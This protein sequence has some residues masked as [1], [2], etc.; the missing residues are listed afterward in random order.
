MRLLVGPP[1]SG[2][3][4]KVLAEFAA[5]AQA[6]PA[7]L[8]VPTATM[9]EHL[10]HEL[11]RQG[12]HVRPSWITTLAG[13]LAEL[14]PGVRIAGAPELAL[15]VELALES[16]PELFCALRGSPGL[17]GALASAIDE[18]SAAGVDAL[19]LESLAGM[20]VAHPDRDLVGLYAAAEKA[21][22]ASGLRLRAQALSQAVSRLQEQ[23]CPFSAV[24]FDGF[25]MFSAAELEFV[26]A[27]AAAVRVTVTLPEWEGAAAAVNR[28]RA[29]GA[30]IDTLQVRRPRPKV[31][32][33][34]AASRD[35]EVE[36]VVLRLLEEHSQGR[37]WREMGVVVRNE[38]E[39]LARF[40]RALFRAGI[41]SR[42]YFGRALWREPVCLL[43]RRFVDA[44][45]SG[46]DGEATVRLLRSPGIVT[47]PALRSGGLR[48]RLVE[49]L[50]FRGL[51]RLGRLAAEAAAPLRPFADWPD[52]QLT[53]RQWAARLRDLV[54]LLEPPPS[55][56]PLGPEEL[57]DYHV[58]AAAFREILDIAGTAA[59]LLPE[60]PVPLAGFWPH[61][62]PALRE[63]RIYPE[64]FRR[65]AVHL[66]DVQEARQWELPVVFVCG[67]LEGEFP[68]R[69]QPDPVLPEGLRQ[70]LAAQG[71]GLRTRQSRE[72]EEQFLFEVARTRATEKLFLSWPARNEKGDEQLRA[73]VLDQAEAEGA[74]PVEARRFAVRPLRTPPLPP[75]P[76]F[77]PDE[78]LGPLRQLHAGIAAT[79]IESFLQCPFQFF[80]ART[81]CLREP[82]RFPARRLDPLFLG[83]LAHA[84]LGEWHQRGGDIGVITMELWD[85]EMRRQGVPETHQALLARE[86]M[87]RN[88]RLYAG[89]AQLEPSWRIELE[90]ELRLRL[91]G[92]EVHGRADRVDIS[93]DGRCIVY[94]FK[95][96]SGSSASQRR[97]REEAG[98]SVQGGLYARALQEEGFRP[99]AIQL[100]L[101]KN[102]IRLVGASSEEEVAG[103]I[104]RAVAAAEK[105]IGEIHAGRIEVLPADPD[106]CSWCVFSDACRVREAAPAA[107]AASE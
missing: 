60:D 67:L 54:R 91:A 47:A 49:E 68:R 2:K 74:R 18:L 15:L 40:E 92:V 51:D 12:R 104:D 5:A 88:L 96:S 16:R 64:D 8:V 14:L 32:L 58:R 27:L 71:I 36:E 21:L 106:Q 75:R 102:E 37:P 82:A 84:I 103:S 81:L 20:G 43:V 59:A 57:R 87:K 11:A 44:V 100:V 95:Y 94:D 93:D 29:L 10:R 97:Q 61:V 6:G 26:S 90:R 52:L 53:P 4:T 45:V 56:R 73:F 42:A 79:A 39:Y 48:D 70:A 38:E 46:W 76:A 24:W 107:L 19:Q 72:A 23:P 17:P 66:L 50:P 13:L 62:E 41:P 85:R 35:H 69:V 105:A 80:A 34:N 98:L 9:A 78:L 63:A 86:A 25:Y 1:G 31:V 55:G 77:L 3:T 33:V 99:Q 101:L 83:T 22:G 89:Q 30:R 28:F 65:D 7:R